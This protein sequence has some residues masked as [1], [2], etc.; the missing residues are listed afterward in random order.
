M[1]DYEREKERREQ[2]REKEKRERERMER[3][4]REL[5][6]KEKLEEN[7]KKAE[8]ERLEKEKIRREQEKLEK[9]KREKERVEFEKKLLEQHYRSS[10]DRS[11]PVGTRREVRR[12]RS[13]EGESE[14]T[15]E[16]ETKKR[17]ERE[18]ESPKKVKKKERR[19]KVKKKENEGEP[20]EEET[21]EQEP[22]PQKKMEDVLKKMESWTERQVKN[23][24]ISKAQLSE[25][26]KLLGM[27]RK[28]LKE[29]EIEKAKLEG[30]LEERKEIVSMFKEALKESGESKVREGVQEEGT[31]RAFAEIVRTE[32]R[33][34]EKRPPVITGTRAEPARST[35]VVLVRKEGRG[36]EEVRKKL[37]ELIDPRKENINVR[38]MTKVKNGIML[39]VTSKEEVEISRR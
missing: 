26:N 13:T 11:P 4:R 8:K 31:A 25:L 22:T 28:K 33:M 12:E 24:T 23:K 29:L 19:E 15:T 18:E 21:P 35:N 1:S 34:K 9:E 37:K 17:K 27:M 38:R 20:I 3:D 36:S 32:R 6:E 10:L 7:E 16:D 5:A 2:D 39:E 14:T 30:R